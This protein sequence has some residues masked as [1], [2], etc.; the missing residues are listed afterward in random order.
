M[1]NKE[2]NPIVPKIK[3]ALSLVSTSTATSL[4]SGN[5]TPQLNNY[6]AIGGI[7]ALVVGP[8]TRVQQAKAMGSVVYE[9]FKA[10]LQGLYDCSD[11]FLPLKTLTGGILAIIDLVEVC[12]DLQQRQLIHRS[13]V[14]IRPCWRIRGN[15]KTLNQSW[16]LSSRSLSSIKNTMACAH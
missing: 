8:E 15:S 14:R 2:G 3:I 13:F 4:N 9:G 7:P 16:K 11:I 6:L 10:V 12:L 5:L 1:T